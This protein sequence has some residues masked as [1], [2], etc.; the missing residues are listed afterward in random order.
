MRLPRLLFRTILLC[1][2]SLA[3]TATFAGAAHVPPVLPLSAS[4]NH[5]NE[6]FS[7]TAFPAGNY[8]NFSFDGAD[9]S[10]CSFAAGSNLTGASFSGAKLQNTNFSGCTLN[11]TTFLG[12]DLS[13]S[14]LPCMGGAS[15]K[16]AILTGAVGGGSGCVECITFGSNLTDA[17]TVNPGVNL[18]MSGGSFR[19]LVSGVVFDDQNSNG[20]LDLGEPGVPGASVN[21]SVAPTVIGGPT[22]F[23]GGYFFTITNGGGGTVSVTLPVGY[24]LVSPAS[25]PI[26]L[27]ACRSSQGLNFAAHSQ[28]TAAQRSTFGRVKALYR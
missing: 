5:T 23:R 28:V 13:F 8:S 18:C 9:L 3:L 11:L 4:S 22:D 6:K 12:A 10:N 26:N 21:V 2:V 24:T 25:L 17:C 7:A 16:G 14:T 19:G 27:G 20:L 1:P 15:F